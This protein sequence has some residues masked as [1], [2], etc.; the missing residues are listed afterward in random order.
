MKALVYHGKSDMRCDTVPDPK[1]EHP[2]D[3]IIRSRPAPSAA[4][5]CISIDGVIPTMEAG[6]VV[7]HETDGRGG[8]GR[9]RR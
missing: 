4:P 5:T 8:R 9:R 1:I 6:D 3:A 7:G 2:R